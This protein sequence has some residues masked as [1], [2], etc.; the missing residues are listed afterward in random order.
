MGRGVPSRDAEVP[1]IYLVLSMA[2]EDRTFDR[3]RSFGQRYEPSIADR[4]GIWL[5]AQQIRAQ[6]G[7][8]RGKAIADFGCGF[9]ATFVR[10]V[11]DEV[12]SATLVDIALAD[13]LKAN[14][15]VKPIEGKLPDALAAIPSASIDVVLSNNVLEHLWE[16]EATLREAKRVLAPNGVCFFNVPSWYGKPLLEAL[17]F[18][19]HMTPKDEIDDHKTYYSPRELWRLLVSAGFKPSGIKCR[20][21]KLG[22]NTFAVC[23]NG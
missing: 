13:D 10:G 9:N 19:L 4:L 11:L 3:H 14:P 17:A 15:K 21:H 2:T 8:F 6:V 22:L 5:S 7:P 18:R 1:L 23:R 16:P 20:F 12:G